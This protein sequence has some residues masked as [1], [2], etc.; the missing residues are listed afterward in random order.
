M[1]LKKHFVKAF[2]S[3]FLLILLFTS[4]ASN[5]ISTEKK[6][7]PVYVTNSNK[8]YL[9]PA[10]EM[11]GSE[12]CLQLLNGVFGETSFTLMIY[13]QADQKGIFMSLLNDFGT[14]MGTLSYDG[15]EVVF[16]SAVFPQNLKAEYILLDIQNAYYKSEAL[17]KLY[18]S[19]GLAFEEEN[20]PENTIRR[21]KS[22]KKIV[23]EITI[24]DNS[25]KIENYLRGYEYNL[26]RGEE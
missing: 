18:E 23:E 17:Q 13:F 3:S 6:I 4:C 8:V 14:D 15:E 22:G 25:I 5:K 24:N 16:D 9:L 7:N 10:E 11:G 26:T 12:D 20:L 2:L 1:I 21:I 19:S